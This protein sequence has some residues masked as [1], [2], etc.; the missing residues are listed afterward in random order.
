MVVRIVLDMTTNTNAVT[1]KTWGDNTV[2]LDPAGLVWNA[3]SKIFGNGDDVQA[4]IES[5]VVVDPHGWVGHGGAPIGAWVAYRIVSLTGEVLWTSASHEAASYY[6]AVPYTSVCE[7]VWGD[8]NIEGKLRREGKL[9]ALRRY[10]G[11]WL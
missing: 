9:P 8:R 6:R 3:H 7:H 4:I 5:A 1:F 10:S 11:A 2:E